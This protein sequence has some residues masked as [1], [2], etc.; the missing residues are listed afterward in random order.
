MSTFLNWAVAYDTNL[1][2][3]AETLLKNHKKSLPAMKQHL[4]SEKFNTYIEL[5][6]NIKKE[7]IKKRIEMC[8]K[9]IE[10]WKL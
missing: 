9:N 4:V 3:K 10:N 5:Q 6:E 1:K 7:D 2:H 8:R